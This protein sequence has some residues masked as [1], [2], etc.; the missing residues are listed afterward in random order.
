MKFESSFEEQESHENLEDKAFFLNNLHAF[1]SLGSHLIGKVIRPFLRGERQLTDD[2][3]KEIDDLYAKFS[4]T[5]YTRKINQ[6]KYKN[7]WYN[8][9]YKIGITHY[10]PS[11]KWGFD[12]DTRSYKFP[13][14][15]INVEEMLKQEIDN[16]EFCRMFLERIP[17]AFNILISLGKD[18]ES[19]RLLNEQIHADWSEIRRLGVIPEAERGLGNMANNRIKNTKGKKYFED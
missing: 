1:H 7:I 17:D 10:T 6:K 9:E 4:E 12:R 13:E 2:E 14:G 19:I 5:D 11:L 3:K 18:E 15:E 8:G 16:N